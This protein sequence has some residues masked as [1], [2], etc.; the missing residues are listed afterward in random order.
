M[1]SI[2]KMNIKLVR[3]DHPRC[4]MLRWNLCQFYTLCNDQKTYLWIGILRE[5][6]IGSPVGY[7][8]N[9]PYLENSIGKKISCNKRSM[10]VMING[11]GHRIKLT[12]LICDEIYESERII[13][14]LSNEEFCPLPF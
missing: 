3:K 11:K 12:D 2:P 1:I 4:K 14:A 9:K 8:G 10:D 7:I 6:P 13:A 5:L